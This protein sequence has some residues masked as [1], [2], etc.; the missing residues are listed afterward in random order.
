[1]RLHLC[2]WFVVLALATALS[3]TAAAADKAATA[4]DAVYL[5]YREP[6]NVSD[7]EC[8]PPFLARE[9]MRQAFLIAARDECG[10]R[11][12]D[13]TLGEKNPDSPSLH[14]VPFD[15]YCMVART[16][17]GFDVRYTLSRTN[18]KVTEKL[19]EWSF[20]TDVFSPNMI[21]N[22]ADLAERMSRGKFKNL[23]NEQKLARPV[24]AAREFAGVP[25]E[26][27]ERL[28][29]WNEIAVFGAL[30]RIHG[31]I[32]AKGESP[33]LLGGLAVGYANLGSLTTS[34][35]SPL[36][37]AFFARAL[38]YAERMVHESDKSDWALWHRAYVRA[39]VGL[40]NAARLDVKAAR[41]AWDKKTSL[42]PPFWA[43]ILEAFCDGQLPK[44]ME[45]A[46][47]RQEQRLARYLKMQ[48]VMYSDLH[49]VTIQTCTDVLQ[50]CPDCL[51][52]ADGLCSTREI[53]PM[54][55]VT[56]SAFSL[57]SNTLRQRLPDV[58]GFPASLAKRVTDSKPAEE[59]AGDKA[60]EDA[61][62]FR[63]Q[64]VADIQAETT[65]GRDTL[66]PSLGVLGNL[67]EELQF[68]QVMR[69]LELEGTIWGIKSGPTIAA[70][71][72][73]CAH[74]RYAAFVDAY[75]GD[76]DEVN[77]TYQAVVAKFET[78]ELVMLDW[79]VLNWLRLR[80][81][82]PGTTWL[83][84]QM[85]HAD[86]VWSDEMNG[87][88][89][90]VPGQPDERHINKPHMDMM[91]DTSSRIPAAVAIQVARNWYRA[92]TFMGTVE[93]DY[94][95]DPILM[96]SLSMRYFKLKQ[97]DNAERCAKKRLATSPDYGAYRNLAAIYEQK[98]DF[99]HWKETLVKSLDLPSA[100]LEQAE[101]QNEI[102]EYHMNR[103]EWSEAVVFA[104]AAA[105]SYSAWSMM[106]ASRCH[107][108]L[109]QWAKAEAF[110]R[111]V[112]ERYD[113]SQFE[114]MRWCHR[115]G[116]GDA[117]A[118]DN[119]ARTHFES[120]GT[121]I[122]GHVRQQVAVYYVLRKEPE[123]AQ[124]VFEMC[125]DEDHQ[126]F[127]ALHAALLAD[128][129]GKTADRDRLLAKIVSPNPA[130]S[131][132]GPVYA[133]MYKELVELLQKALPPGSVK[134]IDFKKIE[135]LT[136]RAPDFEA[137]TN[138]EY[139]VGAFLKNRG[140]KEKSRE[141]L[142]RAAQSDLTVKYNHVFARQTLRDLKIP[143]PEKAV[144]QNS[145][146]KK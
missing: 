78:S 138:F 57:V 37:K 34:Y 133:G 61:I 76:T 9:L 66:E 33:E 80:N 142:I 95:D 14:V 20:I 26:T 51:R 52:A 122:A 30:R 110:I 89:Q 25:R 65:S 84:I 10:L 70:Y 91:W 62:E 127:N 111:A 79:T 21:T 4:G 35:F 121:N 113:G 112:S 134:D 77:K 131:S 130:P 118:A 16:K 109:G 12:P 102:A 145:K 22:L 45:Q 41:K 32:R 96:A 49:T 97:W 48:A 74:H 85:T 98:G 3:G 24:P 53:G 69:R 71:R 40:H 99:V 60:L 36:Q 136:F 29:E 135:A 126:A 27:T 100:G 123:K 73:L 39:L 141:Y 115:T 6:K 55:M 93:N 120:L 116:H 13:A 143:L 68:L 31:E 144:A 146:P 19:G 132:R 90:G 15:L 54:R 63:L 88:I 8:P 114:W 72:P 119:C 104:D 105:V 56:D 28:W 137:P 128:E 125:F 129:L 46:K 44:M 81:M 83:R 87:V 106:T 42:R 107:E 82:E 94:G 47:N 64:L 18:G 67:I 43:D 124:T 17:K 92:R 2:D 75:S 59:M 86:P 23:L 117:E 140:D 11:T 7:P 1:M 58:H 101:V 139:F 5:V 103:K 108:M 38:L 50:D